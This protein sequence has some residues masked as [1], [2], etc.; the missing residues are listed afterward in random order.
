M[1]A[2]TSP[3]TQ[4]LGS[5]IGTYY[6]YKSGFRQKKPYTLV[7]PFDH[8]QSKY[9]LSD[10][11]FTFYNPGQVT[12]WM[13][14]NG[15]SNG[16]QAQ[17]DNV[18]YAKFIGKL[19]SEQRNPG[20]GDEPDAT[21][22]DLGITLGEHKAAREMILKRS[23]NLWELASALARRDFRR[24]GRVVGVKDIRYPKGTKTVSVKYDKPDLAS[25][26]LEASWGWRPM[27][28][29]IGNAL[30]TLVSPLSPSYV[31]ASHYG[32]N[33]WNPRDSNVAGH[34]GSYAWRQITRETWDYKYRSSTG[35]TVTVNNQNVALANRLGVLNI[36]QIWWAT[37]P[38][39]FLIDKYVNIGQLIGSLTDTYGF[40]LSQVWTVRKVVLEATGLFVEWR[41]YGPGAYIADSYTTNGISITKRRSGS[42]L[43]PTLT[44]RSPSIGSYS[45]AVSY[46]ALLVQILRTKS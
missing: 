42:L 40:T 27:V 12:D 16:Q 31:R 30:R 11:R 5:R 46:M 19:K 4:T 39:S 24:A 45:E 38:F 18:T 36:P 41:D 8:R 21:K 13:V 44:L 7:L 15:E 25:L 14:T 6:M 43:G 1:V 33:T 32:V 26:W 28:E 20:S 3:V 29:D 35:A 23:K 2:P 10:N 22:A 34:A 17:I 37:T 9:K